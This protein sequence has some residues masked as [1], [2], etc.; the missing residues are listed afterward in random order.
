[1]IRT[2]DSQDVWPKTLS[3]ILPC[4]LAEA[5]NPSIDPS[6]ICIEPT[7]VLVIQ[8]QF[9]VVHAHLSVAVIYMM[10]LKWE[11]MVSVGFKANPV[12]GWLTIMPAKAKS[13]VGKVDMSFRRIWMENTFGMGRSLNVSEKMTFRVGWANTLLHACM[14]IVMSVLPKRNWLWETRKWAQPTGCP[15]S[16]WCPRKLGSS[17]GVSQLIFKLREVSSHEKWYIYIVR[18]SRDRWLCTQSRSRKGPCAKVW[19]VC[20][21]WLCTVRDTRVDY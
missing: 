13:V 18:K 20:A 10:D 4:G 7:F 1:M 3:H 16:H 21:W 14:L 17:Y 15:L 11:H 19:D 8:L 12:Q 5:L 9:W 6:S 2:K